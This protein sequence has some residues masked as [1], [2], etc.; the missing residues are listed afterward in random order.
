MVPDFFHSGSGFLGGRKLEVNVKIEGVV[1]GENVPHWCRISSINSTE[2]EG[3]A[4]TQME[5]E[6]RRFP[7]QAAMD[8]TNVTRQHQSCWP[9]CWESLLSVSDAYACVAE[10]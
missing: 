6:A 5:V 1:V 10:S 3:L 2:F 8:K 9:M 4:L 7:E